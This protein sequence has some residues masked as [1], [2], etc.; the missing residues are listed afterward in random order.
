MRVARGEQLA[1]YRGQVLA[2]PTPEFPWSEPRQESEHTSTEALPRFRSRGP[3]VA[4]WLF[5]VG[6]L[7]M[8][9][10]GIGS[11][12]SAEDELAPFVLPPTT[13]ALGLRPTPR[14][15]APLSLEESD[16]RIASAIESA[17]AHAVPAEN[18][19][20]RASGPVL[21]SPAV[22]AVAPSKGPRLVAPAPPAHPGRQHHRA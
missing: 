17:L 7:V 22:G 15:D 11:G 13:T 21:P 9:A 5:G 18:A 8:A 16:T 6:A 20:P 14:E 4:A 10:V 12:T 2:R 19:T 3:R 1:P